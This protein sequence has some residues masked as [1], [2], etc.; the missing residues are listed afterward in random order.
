MTDGLLIDNR[1]EK[2]LAR[3]E[4]MRRKREWASFQR[5]CVD[6][7]SHIRIRQSAFEHDLGKDGVSMPPPGTPFFV[8]V[9]FE[10]S[11]DKI[12]GDVERWKE[13]PNREPAEVVF[14]MTWGDPRETTLAKWRDIIR[15]EFHLDVIV[16]GQPT[17][18]GTATQE[19]LWSWTCDVLGIPP[20]GGLSLRKA[21]ELR[22]KYCQ[23]LVGRHAK[24]DFAGYLPG[25]TISGKPLFLP[26]EDIFVPLKVRETFAR[27]VLKAE[28]ERGKPDTPERQPAHEPPEP[29]AAELYEEG[30]TREKSRV[31]EV[32]E[33]LAT[34]PRA[35]ILGDPGAG[36]STLLKYIT[37]AYATSPQ[38]A[39]EHFRVLESRTPILVSVA[40]LSK[41][42]NGLLAHIASEIEKAALSAQ[43]TEV[44]RNDIESGR[45][46]ILLDGLD[47]LLTM[48][49]RLQM[50]KQIQSFVAAHPKN[51]YIISSR[52]IGYNDAPVG[53]NF[54]ELTV[55][56]F[57]DPAI[58]TFS[59]KWSIALENLARGDSPEAIR[60]GEQAGK[61]LHEAIIRNPGVRSLARNP[62]MLTILSLIHRQGKKMPSR[63]VE[64]Y[65]Q[66][67]KTLIESW[68]QAR[69]ISGIPAG[70]AL[71]ERD[72]LDVLCPV[73][74]RM[75]CDYPSG[76]I[77]AKELR[78]VMI[79]AMMDGGGTDEKIAE[80]EAESL[81]EVMKRQSGLI[82]ERGQNAYGF[83]HLTFQEYLTA[84]HV[85]MDRDKIWKRL[86]PV[87]H[88]PRWREVV[89]LTAG[90]LAVLME[91]PQG[92]EGLINEMRNAGSPLENVLHRD[93]LLS[94]ECIC[95]D[96]RISP[97]A[98]LDVVKQGIDLWRTTA[99]GQFNDRLLE[100]LSRVSPGQAR[101]QVDDHFVTRLTD[102]DVYV[103]LRAAKAL[104]RF[105]QA[106]P[107]VVSALVKSLTDSDE[108]VR[109]VAARALGRLGQ[110][111]PEVVS[112][113][114]KSLTDSDQ[115]VRRAAAEALGSL[116]EASPEVVS[117]LVKSLTDSDEYVRRRAAEALGSLGQ[118]SPEVLSALVK[119]LEDSKK[120][121]RARAAVALG[122]LGLAGAEVVSA[123]VESLKDSDEVVPYAAAWALGSLAGTSS[124]VVLALVKSLKDSDELVRRRAA[125]ALA[126]LGEASPEVVSALMNSLTDSDGFVRV[127]ASRALG[128]LGQARPEV[129][130]ALVKSLTDSSE[131]VRGGGAGAL[132][133]L[134][135]ASPE[136]VSALVKTLK[137]SSEYVRRRAAEALAGLG[138]ASPEVV[139][140]LVKSLTD[141][142]WEV[143]QEAGHALGSLCV[144]E[145]TALFALSKVFKEDEDSGVADS[146]YDALLAT[147]AKLDREKYGEPVPCE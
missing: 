119:S 6:L 128:R 146:A 50:A 112:A 59:K 80:R 66:C 93:L 78:K 23:W 27:P 103:R 104:G 38:P 132:R 67:T 133:S 94:L 139:S 24:V 111:S 106:S 33:A 4:Q 140:A 127:V 73:A 86:R 77:P 8:S 98:Q 41:D 36:K 117:T 109:F 7:L 114:V 63:R 22:A 57:D 52:I 34:N 118:A 79:K 72:I 116:G 122:R 26:L 131:Y 87:L 64:L 51:A 125:E 82:A 134:G 15:S 2:L 48:S 101:T 39:R 144:G 137:D 147:A 49:D 110:A 37:L 43:T 56:P 129:V 105:R 42:P 84:K 19:E 143:R 75:H 70:E 14:F 92:C 21:G 12:R 25:A 142:Q 120:Y 61:D 113:L 126:R 123:L 11:L 35:V 58:E 97:A 95:D 121:V 136:V 32:A 141:S 135:E 46:I 62:L 74:F 124:D 9:S 130:S 3:I 91:D 145:R 81:L 76:V 55:E 90:C 1:K 40:A 18:L 71:D 108:Y 68:S 5:F 47:E 89:L 30:R 100:L 138:Q 83:L 45:A 107:E 60:K 102:S 115:Y 85:A 44:V 96:L 20:G 29:D 53:P 16:L 17:I 99:S 31:V 13:D 28:R 54:N 65:A 10:C 69:D 88:H